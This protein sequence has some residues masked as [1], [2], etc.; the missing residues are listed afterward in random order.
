[1]DLRWIPLCYP[2]WFP[3]FCRKRTLR[4]L[5]P[6]L[7]ASWFSFPGPDLWHEVLQLRKLLCIQQ[8]SLGRSSLSLT[9]RPV[10]FTIELKRF[11]LPDLAPNKSIGLLTKL[12]LQHLRTCCW[13]RGRGKQFPGVLFAVF[14][15]E[16]TV[17][18]VCT[19]IARSFELEIWE[20]NYCSSTSGTIAH[21]LLLANELLSWN[22]VYL[23][24]TEVNVWERS[25]SLGP[26]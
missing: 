1:M 18:S 12:K 25:L 14:V 5:L 11:S 19:S 24:L 2:L 15:L 8:I 22:G 17:P 10:T 6:F 20:Q 26:A 3:F 23:W 16:A 4:R 7:V 9:P 21:A 13:F